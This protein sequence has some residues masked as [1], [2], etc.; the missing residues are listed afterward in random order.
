MI[1][2][3]MALRGAAMA[4]QLLLSALLLRDARSVRAGRYGALFAGGAAA[5]VVVWA[6]PFPIDPALWLIPLRVLAFGNTAVFWL[7]ATALFDDEFEPSWV[8]AAAWLFLV[9]LGLGGLYSGV[10]RP[11]L[12]FNALSLVLVFLALGQVL[13]GRAL[14]LVESRRRLRVVLVVSVGLFNTAVSVT[15]ITVGG[16]GQPW[17]GLAEQLVSVMLSGF[18]SMMILSVTRTTPLLSLALMESR[19]AAPQTAAG[20]PPAALPGDEDDEKLL[21]SLRALMEKEKVYREE[22]LSIAILAGKL[23]LPEYRLRRLINQRLGHR[24]FSTFLNGHR[25]ADAMAALADPTQADVPI[26]TIAL[27]AGFQSIGP[28]NR[29][30]KAQAGMTPTEFRRQRRGA[31]AASLRS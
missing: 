11:Y 18:F 26:L 9:A 31:A 8:H 16:G 2:L 28:F 12:A 20:R 13:A 5:A 29:A 15:A 22:G 21:A 10:S 30:F 25:L 3:L 23:D 27:D 19:D 7:L 6:P 17:F 24:N 14:D 4:L 1:A